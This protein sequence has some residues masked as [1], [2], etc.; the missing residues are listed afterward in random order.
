MIFDF[1]RMSIAGYVIEGKVEKGSKEPKR[2][3][4]KTKI[5]YFFKG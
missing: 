5:P 1:R 4:N 2:M 3:V